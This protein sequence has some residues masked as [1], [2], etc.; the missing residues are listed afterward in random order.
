[1]IAVSDN[2]PLGYLVQ[3]GRIALLPNLFDR[4]VIPSA[5]SWELSRRETP[6]AVRRWAM[7]LPEWADVREPTAGTDRTR[8]G[9]GEREAILI[10]TELDAILL[11]DDRQ[12][13]KHGRAAG[14]LVTGT[15][16]V[17]VQ[18]HVKNLIEIRYVSMIA[19]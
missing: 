13:V 10:A 6:E 1:M 15:L 18:A 12:G 3:I 2:G 4:I 9:A 16:G 7:S 19:E 14:L 11:C 5:V 17:L 8:P